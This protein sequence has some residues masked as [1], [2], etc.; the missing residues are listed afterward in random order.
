MTAKEEFL[1]S[2]LRRQYNETGRACKD[3]LHAIIRKKKKPVSAASPRTHAH[4]E[5]DDSD[6]SDNENS[7]DEEDEDDDDDDDDEFSH[8][9]KD[10]AH[11]A[12]A[13]QRVRDPS[14][15][16]W[17][18]QPV[19]SSVS[20]VSSVPVALPVVFAQP[21]LFAQPKCTQTN[22]E[23]VGGWVTLSKDRPDHLPSKRAIEKFVSISRTLY[24]SQRVKSASS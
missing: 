24:G 23:D 19:V 22:A 11:L 5:S 15:N 13:W 12:G 9:I 16:K 3:Y 21:V 10:V 17:H 20:S 8:D 14:T 18:M 4:D 6:D 7:E 2:R 1:Y